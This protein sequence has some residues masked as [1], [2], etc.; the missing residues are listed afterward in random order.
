MRMVDKERHLHATPVLIFL[1]SVLV[2]MVVINFISDYFQ[3]LF[4]FVFW[5]LATNYSS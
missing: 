3:K 1:I 4:L 2:F 5:L